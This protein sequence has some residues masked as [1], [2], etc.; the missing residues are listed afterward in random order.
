MRRTLLIAC[1]LLATACGGPG[2]PSPPAGPGPG[3]GP[4]GPPVIPVRVLVFSATAGFRHD[5]IDTARQT[6]STL[7][8]TTG[9]F[10]VTASENLADLTESRLGA[11]DVLFFALTS[12]ELAIDTTQ[13]AAILA[14]VNSGGGFIGV[15]SATDM[16]RTWP[17]Y[18]TLV[19]GYFK[20]HP[21]T[22]TATVT[23]EDRA[24]PTT[25]ALGASFQILEEFYTFDQNPRPSVHVLLS[26]DASSVGATGDYPLAWTRS[27]GSGRVYYNALGHFSSTW[28]DPRFQAQMRAAIAWTGQ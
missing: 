16:F 18:G 15:H 22:Q 8:T 28:T 13:K 25:S 7:A 2:T 24:H 26:L 4:G 27:V 9:E 11:F 19:G 17:E 3:P 23:V 14:F 21:W 5:S 12:G 10:T 1:A 6:L 20:E